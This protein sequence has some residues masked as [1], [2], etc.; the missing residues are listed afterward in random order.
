[1]PALT[2]SVSG[3]A[4]RWVA[5]PAMKQPPIFRTGDP[6]GLRGCFDVW[7]REPHRPDQF[8][9]IAAPALWDFGSS[10]AQYSPSRGV[11]Q[12]IPATAAS[13]HVGRTRCGRVGSPLQLDRRRI[14]SRRLASAWRQE[15]PL[16]I[17]VADRLQRDLE[18]R[19]IWKW[20]GTGTKGR[21]EIGPAIDGTRLCAAFE[22]ICTNR[23]RTERRRC[24]ATVHTARHRAY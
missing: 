5:R 11:I 2:T 19:G 15:L 23:S 3:S 8:E 1:M 21:L 17:R 12:V 13:S 6:S 18:I 20:V 24:A 7:Q 16:L 14:P 4:E 10:S 9:R 22:R